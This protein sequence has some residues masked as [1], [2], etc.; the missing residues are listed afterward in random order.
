MR[1]EYDIFI[2]LIVALLLSV[3]H[4]EN[5]MATET[6]A[7]PRM[8]INELKEKLGNPDTVIID[9]RR[10]KN[11]WSSTNK[12]LTARREDPAKVSQWYTTYPQDKIFVFYC[13]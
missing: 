10:Q 1:R 9:V 3:A 5:L 8:S 6:V 12:I 2:I 13:S 4:S 7:V 11:W